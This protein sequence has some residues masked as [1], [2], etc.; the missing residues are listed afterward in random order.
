MPEP[1]IAGAT[2]PN[3][4]PATV[5]AADLSALGSDDKFLTELFG[6]EA[7]PATGSAANPTP[8][9]TATED[10]K[11]R[12]RFE[13]WQGQADR[14][15]NELEQTKPLATEYQQ[16]KPVV[17]FLKQNP[18]AFEQI[19][20]MKEKNVSSA[21]AASTLQEPSKPAK[22][23]NYNAVEAY[24]NPESESFR[25]RIAHDEYTRELTEFMYAKQKLVETQNE[26]R[27]RQERER[28]LQAEKIN[29]VGK[30]LQTQYGFQPEQVQDFIQTMN[31]P[32]SMSM[33]N[34]VNLYKV[35]KHRTKNGALARTNAAPAPTLPPP[36]VIAG[37]TG[38]QTAPTDDDAFMAGIS[39]YG[40]R[41]VSAPR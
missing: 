14:Y 8:A 1:N 19:I 7:T 12:Q 16:F 23:A 20:Q 35:I 18:E 33:D 21:S 11:V 41:T 25:Y 27:I 40:R 3:V 6:S 22:P 5:S 2:A 36:P 15:R 30:M 9:S 34:M 17:E 10:D 38:A 26:Q 31:D 24:N 39:S 29:G 28:Q 13:Y 4:D 37:G 32:N